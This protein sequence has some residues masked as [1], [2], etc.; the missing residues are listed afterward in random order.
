MLVS[1]SWKQTSPNSYNKS[2][3]YSAK[4][5]RFL[6]RLSINCW[7]GF[8]WNYLKVLLFLG[9][10]VSCGKFHLM[11][12][13]ETLLTTL[14]HLW[15]NLDIGPLPTDLWKFKRCLQIWGFRGYML[16]SIL[17]II[18]NPWE[19]NLCSAWVHFLMSEVCYAQMN[20]LCFTRQWK[21]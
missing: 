7:V 3:L 20:E 12:L 21:C 18:H 17:S 9:H 4:K 11:Y 5:H 6:Q 14:R 16:P 8:S 19:T 15:Q 2:V 1:N 10:S 13:L